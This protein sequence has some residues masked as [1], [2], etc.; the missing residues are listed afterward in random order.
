MPDLGI[1]AVPGDTRKILHNSPALPDNAVE[2][3]RFSGIG[4]ADDGNGWYHG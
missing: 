3:S 2:K 4:T 1:V